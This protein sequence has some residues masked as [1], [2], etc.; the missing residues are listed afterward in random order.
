[1]TS[2]DFYNLIEIKFE[3]SEKL[4]R[5]QLTFKKYLKSSVGIYSRKK[6]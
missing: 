1:M 2:R 5:Y 6:T 4:D 3:T